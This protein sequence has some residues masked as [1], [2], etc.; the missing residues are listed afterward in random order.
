MPHIGHQNGV[1]WFGSGW[2][3]RTRWFLY[4]PSPQ[5]GEEENGKKKA[6]LLDQ[7]KDSLT[8]WQRK[9]TVTTIIPIK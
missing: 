6:K 4:R 9:K 8:E 7:D 5:W 3:Q 2:Q 1:S